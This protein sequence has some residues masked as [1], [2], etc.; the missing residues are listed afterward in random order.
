[1][2]PHGPLVPLASLDFIGAPIADFGSSTE[3]HGPTVH[4][5]GSRKNQQRPAGKPEQHPLWYCHTPCFRKCRTDR[6]LA[7]GVPAMT[8]QPEDMPE[9]PAVKVLTWTR[10]Q[11]F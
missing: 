11:T 10:Y 6:K 9:T 3:N 7:T 8:A 5:D 4:T 2:S 1:M